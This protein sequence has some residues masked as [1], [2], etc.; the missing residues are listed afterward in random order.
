MKPTNI[1]N[2]F[3]L[4]IV[5]FIFLNEYNVSQRIHAVVI[6]ILQMGLS[7]GMTYNTGFAPP[8]TPHIVVSCCI[9]GLYYLF[10]ISWNTSVTTRLIELFASYFIP[11]LLWVIFLKIKISLYPISRINFDLHI[12]TCSMI[13]LLLSALVAISNIPI[14]SWFLKND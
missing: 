10:V 7:E 2:Y 6:G 5:L 12:D 14:K 13:G 9:I 3:F 1:I 11:L 4:P 8:S